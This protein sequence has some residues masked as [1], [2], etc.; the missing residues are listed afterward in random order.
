MVALMVE[1]LELKGVERVV[2]VGTGSGYAT[3]VLSELCGEVFTL[4]VVKELAL[5]ARNLLSSLG[6]RNVSAL[7]GDGT[8]GWEEH[9]P[10][11]A[12]I[13][14]AAAPCIPRPLIEQLRY[15]VISCS[16]W[17]RKSFKVWCAF[18][19]TEQVFERSIWASATL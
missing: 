18:A 6:C 16:R 5:K 3:A 10:Y 19:K 15:P 4:E 13:I 1:A 7:V 11:D 9:S 14:S 12:V 8:L 2:E 17:A